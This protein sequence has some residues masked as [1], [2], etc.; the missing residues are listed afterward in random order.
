MSVERHV[1]G[2]VPPLATVLQCAS[3]KVL[4]SLSHEEGEGEGKELVTF[5]TQELA[6]RLLTSMTLAQYTVSMS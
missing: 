4:C 1:Q 6:L 5:P 2:V 3:A